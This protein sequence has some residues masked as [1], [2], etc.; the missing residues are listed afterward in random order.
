MSEFQLYGEVFN[1][2]EWLSHEAMLKG[3]LN[4]VSD[5][6][7]VDQLMSLV[8]GLGSDP[9]TLESQREEDKVDKEANPF[10]VPRD[11]NLTLNTHVKRAIAFGNDLSDVA[12]SLTINDGTAILDQMGFVCKAATM[13][14]TA[15]YRSPR[16]NNLFVA[17]DFH[18]LDIQIDELLKMIPTVDTL[19]P[20]LAAFKGNANFHLAGESYLFANYKPKMSTLLGSAAINGKNLV[21]FDNE[22]L[23]QVA[24]LMQLKSWKEKDN[25]IHVDSISVELT[26]FRKEIEVFP[27]V[28]SIGN[29]SFCAAGKHNLDNFG[30]YHLE[31]LKNPL[32]AR[33]AVD[34]NGPLSKPQ[35][36][37]GSI[38]Y[39]DL[40][41]PEKQGAA[42]AQAMKMKAMVRSAL[43]ANVR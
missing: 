42:E 15:I 12:G 3:D 37:L 1:L 35:I 36:K 31:L 17:L 29:Y 24:K 26:C 7:D 8:S 5:Y 4:F 38:Q 23:S 33:V 18:L 32:L 22:T 16:P 19:V 20:M 28:V 40:Y 6:A 13:Q 39:A 25:T 14:L 9:D 11:V 21:V 2:E 34:V 41:K 30:N 27:F 10:I 43:E